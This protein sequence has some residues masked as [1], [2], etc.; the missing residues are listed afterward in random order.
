MPYLARHLP[1]RM[2]RPR[3]APSEMDHQ[4]IAKLLED[5][6]GSE[7]RWQEAIGALE[8]GHRDL[9]AKAEEHLSEED[10][11]RL[12]SV[13]V[14]YVGQIGFRTPER[15]V[16]LFDQA[17]S[18]GVHILPVHYGNPVPDTRALPE[19]L[20]TRTRAL[21]DAI[22]LDLSR[23]T[24]FLERLSRWS[25]EVAGASEAE[26]PGAFRWTNT[27]F[28]PADAVLYYCTIRELRPMTVI[29][30]GG[31]FS[32]MI[33]AAAAARNGGT[34]L[35]CIEPEP[36]A[37][38]RAGFPGLARLIEKPVQE[39]ELDLFESLRAGDVVFVDGS[40][41]ARIGSDVN[42][43][44]AEVIPRLQPE[45]VLHFHDIFTPREYPERWVKDLQLFWT[46]Q[47]LLEAFLLY[48]SAFE[49]LCMMSY[50]AEV[51]EPDVRRTLSLP[52]GASIRGSSA[53]LKRRAV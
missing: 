41:V 52:G 50:L 14:I 51:A 11:L 16:N 27:E 44:F 39:V 15:K 22:G 23:Q 34:E 37:E 43:V 21:A 47:Y 12:L 6:L 8:V 29:E 5:H 20:W 46:E 9:I 38:L 48:N 35:V 53:W 32:T 1:G 13:L 30:V 33:A 7:A 18:M 40:H 26:L 24:E 17:Q 19:G 31:G 10:L 2:R 36:S 4:G 45:V 49:V 42:H 3:P 25:P 28:P